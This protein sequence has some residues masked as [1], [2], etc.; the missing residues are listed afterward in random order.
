V[1][2]ADPQEEI[3]EFRLNTVTYGLACALFLAMRTLRQ[4]AA[5]EAERFPRGALALQK[6][7]YMDDILTG[8]AALSETEELRTQLMEICTAGGFP[9]RKWSA[10]LSSLLAAI[11]PDHIRLTR[12]LLDWRPQKAHN[13]LGLQ[14]HP[15]SDCF[16]YAT[17]C[18]AVSTF[19]KRFV[20]SLASR[21]F[22]PL[23]W[24]VPTVARAKIKFQA[25]WLLGID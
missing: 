3:K 1:W 12:E 24:L 5:D 17:S 22:D 16:L 23:G 25:T 19:T 6:D 2:R 15:Y 7:V 21:L 4:L 14:W 13:T 8:A 10:N 20:L 9:L 18:I 11:P